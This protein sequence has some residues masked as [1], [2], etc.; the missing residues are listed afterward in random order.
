MFSGSAVVDENNTTGFFTN[1]PEKKGLV[2]IYTTDNAGIQQQN[3]A[4]STDKGRT[5]T[6]YEGNPVIKT[7][8]DPLKDGAFRDPKVFWHEES[9]KW[10]MVLAGGP[11]RFFSSSDL[12]TWIPEA[13]QPDIHT[14]CPDLLKINIEGTDEYKW[15]LSEGGRYYRIGDFKQVNGKW[16]FVSETD[17]ISMNF[18]K[19]SY[20]AQTYNNTP[21]GRIIM[22]NWMNTW[23]NYCNA[24][25]AITDP[26]NGSFNLQH[27]LKLK[28]NSDGQVRLYQ[29]A[30]KEYDTLRLKPI[31]LNNKS[32]SERNNILK[33]ISAKQAEIVA[34]F[35]PGENTTDVGF[36]LRVG[37]N[38]ETIVNYN[39]DSEELTIDRKKSGKIPT[40]NGNR[41]YESDLFKAVQ[42]G[43]MSKTEEGKIKLRIFLDWSSIEVFGN[44]GEVTGASLIFPDDSSTAMEAYSKGEDSTA[45]I[46]IYPINSIWRNEEASLNI[47]TIDIS[48][49]GDSLE[50]TEFELYDLNGNNIET[51][52]IKTDSNG[53]VSIINLS[54][55]KYI[56]KLVN[57]PRGYEY[58]KDW[59]VQI[60]LTNGSKD[61]EVNMIS[62]Y[63]KVIFKDYDGKIISEQKV[64]KGSSAKEPELP[65]REGYTFTG[66]DKAFD[67]VT[68][69]LIVTATYKKNVDTIILN[70]DI[71]KIIERIKEAINETKPGETININGSEYPYIDSKIFES[72]KGVDRVFKFTVN[73]QGITLVW[74]FNGKDIEDANISVDLSLNDESNNKE[75]IEKLDSKAQIISFRNHGK[76][77]V[78]MTI[79]IPVDTSKIDISKPIYIYHFNEENKKAEALEALKVYKNKDSYFV[80]VTFTH[81][82]DYFLS[83][84]DKFDSVMEEPTSSD[85]IDKPDKLVQTGSLIPINNFM[86]IGFVMLASGAYLM[87]KRKV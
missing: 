59:S 58:D 50:G 17:S 8:D 7:S 14:E 1:T 15:V 21:D 84:R 78:P 71:N 25:S 56:L 77:P 75:I 54:R 74:S 86:L 55:N 29:E 57:A 23:D 39:I 28:K 62:L 10:M 22:I 82:S 3:I 49:S 19:D 13:M 30:V 42:S 6:K 37:K 40:E 51:G 80:D 43:Y 63:R 32:V 73:S 52:T 47:N 24:I 33:G 41:N 34:E 81:N 87:R 65:T 48:K 46:S 4:Y 12:K 2:A 64:L 31:V 9:Q 45:D 76:L 5:W 53:K 27:E 44:D 70:K 61:I 36:K 11:L 79:T 20:A 83:N 85:S 35:T 72:I 66:W 67:N 68:D 26:Y 18:G 38:Q 69:D 60:D 16:T